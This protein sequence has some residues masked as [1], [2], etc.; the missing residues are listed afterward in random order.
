MQA[1]AINQTNQS[2][3]QFYLQGSVDYY[4]K[5]VEPYMPGLLPI[6]IPAVLFIGIRTVLGKPRERLLF[7][8]LLTIV[9]IWLLSVK[10]QESAPARYHVLLFIFCYLAIARSIT[11]FVEWM[12]NYSRKHPR[13]LLNNIPAVF[14]YSITILAVGIV[15]FRQYNFVQDYISMPTY[16]PGSYHSLTV[17]DAVNWIEKNV[18]QGTNILVTQVGGVQLSFLTQAQYFFHLAPLNPDLAID[19]G[20]TGIN[21][22]GT[23][24]RGIASGVK[25]V[26]MSQLLFLA[27]N[28]YRG[29]QTRN[30]G[31]LYQYDLLW[32]IYSTE[33]EYFYL[34][35]PYWNDSINI[36]QY[37]NTN[38]AFQKIY[39]TS[40]GSH[41]AYIYKVDW[42]SLSYLE[43]PT[44]LDGVSMVKIISNM[45]VAPDF[46]Y[47]TNQFVRFDAK[48]IA[49][50]VHTILGRYYGE[51]GDR[52]SSVIEYKKA[53]QV[54][55]NALSASEFSTSYLK[56]L[57]LPEK[58]TFE[59]Q[60]GLSG[61]NLIKNGG[62]EDG[63]IDWTKPQLNKNNTSQLL[64]N[65][66]ISTNAAFGK[67]SAF[68]ETNG[69]LGNGWKQHV[70]LEANHDY[71]YSVCYKSDNVAQMRILLGSVSYNG[72]RVELFGGEQISGTTDWTCQRSII[73]SLS[74]PNKLIMDAFPVMLDRVGK[75]WIDNVRL[76]QLNDLKVDETTIVVNDFQKYVNQGDIFLAQGDEKQA[77]E[78]YQYAL[79]SFEI[80]RVQKYIST[81]V[82]NAHLRIV[83]GSDNLVLGQTVNAIKEFQLALK[84][85]TQDDTEDLAKAYLGL[86]DTFLAQRDY[87]QAEENY[88]QV[89]SVDP[90]NRSVQAKLS[91]VNAD[92][93]YQKGEILP[94]VSFY[95][96]AELQNTCIGQSLNCHSTYKMEDQFKVFYEFLAHM[97]DE[98][99]LS[100][101]PDIFVRSDIFFMPDGI[102]PVLFEHPSHHISFDLILIPPAGKLRFGITLSPQVWKLGMGDGVQ[103]NV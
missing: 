98:S 31:G 73:D 103:F 24:L 67:F 35:G 46:I 52:L 94:A 22:W 66:A 76:I 91:E 15:G 38:P 80:D 101:H 85:T 34:Y 74:G 82:D 30:M 93:A 2:L 45:Y 19:P 89:Y 20:S 63:D 65:T 81:N 79:A 8:L 100:T 54:Y 39:Y 72:S 51:Q 37:L 26:N 77:Y 70:E 41:W 95:R 12:Q 60:D 87:A 7:V 56:Y 36:V 6:S 29:V 40:D 1:T 59:E 17:D 11:V 23:E 44:K 32:Q 53:L 96:L 61:Q 21:S 18:S 3:V 10:R 69:V 33:S 25:P 42:K 102:Y 50:F 43:Y 83:L 48:N 92:Q 78:Q 86:G 97:P 28:S 4:H 88:Q 99:N 5:F 75:V 16:Q 62:F 13:I 71:L 14:I 9:P 55:P 68:M 27:N 47:Q 58:F 84:Q 57:G 49:G 90:T 64:L